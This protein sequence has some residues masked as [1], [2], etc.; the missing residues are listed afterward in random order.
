MNYK[1]VMTLEQA[2]SLPP[3]TACVHLGEQGDGRRPY[4]TYMCRF[5]SACDMQR[6]TREH[7]DCGGLEQEHVLGEL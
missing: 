7:I 5:Q 3:L 1:E 2:Q 6:E 4:C